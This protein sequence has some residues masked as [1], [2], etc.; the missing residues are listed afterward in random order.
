[1]ECKALPGLCTASADWV[2]I[3]TLWNVKFFAVCLIIKAHFV[4]IDTLWNVKNNHHLKSPRLQIVEIDTLWNVK[5]YLI[6]AWVLP[7][8]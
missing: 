1:M 6:L 8:M 3:D 7:E 5:S 4:E 2:E